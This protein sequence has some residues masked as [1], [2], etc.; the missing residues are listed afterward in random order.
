M[1]SQ[2]LS[3]SSQPGVNAIIRPI[4]NGCPASDSQILYLSD[5]DVETNPK[6]GDF[7]GDFRSRLP[8]IFEER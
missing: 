3:F 8:E 6:M 5:V 2:T 1:W 4:S 7:E